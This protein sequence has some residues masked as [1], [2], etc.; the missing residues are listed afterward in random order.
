MK[1]M[2]NKKFK[3]LRTEGD[4]PSSTFSISGS[5]SSRL[6]GG[7]KVFL[8]ERSG[9][10]CGVSSSVVVVVVVIFAL[11]LLSELKCI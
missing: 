5:T 9:I 2:Y 7:T 10:G 4:V 1:S 11:L 8:L 6:G 3:K